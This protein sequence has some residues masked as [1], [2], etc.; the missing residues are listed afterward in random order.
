M[1]ADEVSAVDSQVAALLTAGLL[2][3]D[4]QGRLQVYI[5]LSKGATTSVAE[6]ESIGVIVE[7]ES[8]DGTILQAR[9]SLKSLAQLAELDSVRAVTP[10]DY[11]HVN[12]GS[13]LTEGDAL[14]DFDDLRAT[15]GVD[16]TGVTVGVLS[17]GISGLANAIAAGDLP[18]TSFSRDGADKL[19]S[20]SG[21]LIATS[22]RADGDLESGA[23]GTAM[24]EIVHDIAPGAQLRFANFGTSLEFIAAV[25]F[26]A[27]NSDVVVDDIGF[28]GVPYDQ[29]SA[30]SVNTSIELNRATNPIRGYYNAVGN[31]ALAHYQGA[32]VDSGFDGA[33]F[34]GSPGNF[35]QF[36]PTVDTTDCVGAGTRIANFLLLG[37]G[38]TVT[39]FLTWNDTWGAPTGDYDLY[40]LDNTNG[41]VVANSFSD[42]PGVT[43]TPVEAVAFTNPN[44]VNRFYDVFIHNFQ[45]ASGP[46][47]FDMFVFGGIPC[48][49]GSIF[50]YNTM[51][52]SVSAQSDAGG[53]VISAGAINAS[54]PGI[55]DIASYSSRGPTNNGAIKPDVTAIDGVSV[56]GSGGFP[57][58]FFGTSAAA[59]HV[60]GLAALLLALRPSLL[61]GEPGDDPT[62]DRSLLRAIIMDN[63][64]DLGVAG[65]DN[66]Y[67]SGRVD[68]ISAAQS[69]APTISI[70]PVSVDEGA[71]S[72]TLTISLDG[73]SSGTV[74]VTYA[75]SNGTAV[76]PADFTATSATATITAGTTATTIAIP[77]TDDAFDEEDETF[78]V[79]LSNP[80]SAVLSATAASA[81][82]TITDN[83]PA[84]T[85]SIADAS[86][87]EG[88]ASGVVAVTIRLDAIFGRVVTVSYTT[89][90]GTAV[91]PA[92]YIATS[93][94]T[95]I[96]AGT[97]SADI[98]IP[99]N[100][101]ALDEL[102]ETFAVSL[103]DPSR[104]TLSIDASSAT[105][106]MVDND[107]AP[108]V[109]AEAT[110]R[111]VEGPAGTVITGDILVALSAISGLPVRIE[112]DTRDGTATAA[113]N[114]Y[115]PAT[116]GVMTIAPGNTTGTVQV[117]IN[118][119][120][121]FELDEAFTVTLSNAT[122]ASGPV[123][124]TQPTTTVT[125]VSDDVRIDVPLASGFNLI[126]V[127]VRFATTTR[128]KDLA[129]EI[130]EQ[131]GQVS[132]IL[133]WNAQS[134]TFSSWVGVNPDTNN[135]G[136]AEGRGYFV[137]VVS[138]P[139]GGAWRATGASIT[140][141]VPLDLAVGFNLVSV[142]FSSQPYDA[143]SL[144]QAVND[145]G[146]NVSSMLEWKTASQTFATWVAINPGANPF[147]I[148]PAA[149]Y[150]V[151]VTRQTSGPFVP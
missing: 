64:V 145:A 74:T 82:V 49:N 130:V 12:V 52:S 86:I 8:D 27:A 66:T 126:G 146:G 136:L 151:R 105:V 110:E 61:S 45:N 79:T 65:I 42:N 3:L 34:V 39:I 4:A 56:T 26:L 19:V 21:G 62:A 36:G 104:A 102:D 97:L 127:P 73:V 69:L 148:L 32:W 87:D 55:D 51:K 37:P 5:H 71:G 28:F 75:T 43:G 1:T 140:E 94:T 93:A 7:R 101:D 129:R 135:L 119:D 80:S 98:A 128:F 115:V 121:N 70:T 84:P 109:A 114:D 9:V 53:G 90:D 83:D 123:V 48:P 22:L 25:D 103:S 106:T 46:K 50:V 118:G 124:I 131:G 95:T 133:A 68:A 149:G 142:P 58:Q 29:T 57:S 23:E 81:T 143:T 47:T 14:L 33:A 76:A 15:F 120:D 6:L 132:S 11:G 30:V 122:T 54:E 141:S 10:P 137:R 107:P 96:A 99:I 134:Q 63:A 40:L 31:Q 85:L 59:P 78:T 92:D 125:I 150:F 72:T 67:G 113:D 2:A 91:A 112:Y 117:I 144:A 100:D 108:S 24:L 111:L 20:T 16:G 44:T 35:H 138:A 17:D 116:R 41:A 18:A 38:Q 13:R 89:S 139:A 77:I 88:D 60:A 147:D